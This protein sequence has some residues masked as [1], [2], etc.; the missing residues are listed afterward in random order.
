MANDGRK[1][2][3]PRKPA[4]L[5]GEMTTDGEMHANAEAMARAVQ[6]SPAVLARKTVKAAIVRKGARSGKKSMGI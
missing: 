2:T 4:Q 3:N 5:A 6:V 1:S